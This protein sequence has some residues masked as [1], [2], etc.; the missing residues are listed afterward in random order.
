[1][2]SE[3]EQGGVAPGTTL[4][5]YRI[6]RLLGRGGMGAVFLA[7]DTTLHRQVAL[8]VMD[9]TADGEMSRTRVLREARNAAALNHPNICTI[10][11]V[12]E[13]RGAPF[14]AMEYVE[15]HSL[16]D[17]LDEAALSLDEAVRYGV[18]AADALAYA[19]DHGV[20]HRDFKVANA[21]ITTAGC[22]KVVDFGLARRGDAM[23]AS[24]TTMPSLVPAGAA[25]GTPY[26]MAPEQVRADPTDARTDIWALGVLLYEMVAGAKPFVGPTSPELF[27]SILRDAPRPLPATVPGDMRVL[28]ERCLEKQPERRYQ[29]AAEV[30]A[31]LEA[32]HTGT[33]ASW[34]QWRYRLSRRRWLVPA[35]SLVSIGAILV[36][37]DVGSV[38]E[39]LLGRPP[40]QGPIR[41]AV[42]PFKNLT[43][44]PEQEY[45]SDGLTD[46][47]ITQLGRLQPERLNVIARTSSM[48]Y[49]TRDDPIDQIGRELGV[50]Y[51]MEGSARREGSRVRISATLIRARDQTQLWTD[52]FERELSGILALQSD[53]ARGVAGS[54]AL[55]LLPAQERRLAD[56][57]PV[58]PEAY[59]AL[60]AGMQHFWKLTPPEMDTAEQY[61][62]LSLRRDPN[63][64]AAHAA[65]AAVWSGRLQMGLVPWSDG[66][67]KVFQAAQKAVELDAS[68]PQAHYAMFLAQWLQWNFVE[69]ER[70][71]QKALALNPNYADAHA[72]YSHLL[73]ILNR[74]QEARAEINRALDLDPFNATWHAFNG[75]DLVYERRWD[76]AITEVRGAL[77]MIPELPMAAETLIFAFHG[78]GSYPEAADALAAYAGIMGYV[79][80]QEIM[81]QPGARA[82]YRQLM[83]RA[84]DALAART[85]QPNMYVSYYDILIFYTYSGDRDRAFEWIRKAIDTHDPNVAYLRSPDLL[86]S[87]RDDP[88]LKE[89]DGAA[90]ASELTDPSER[91]C[92]SMGWLTPISPPL[93]NS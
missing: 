32:I 16:G 44:D 26:A 24:A 5:S 82:D 63:Y 59:E 25:A 9:G 46:E 33:G 61:V 35:A 56:A 23:I 2:D 78:K 53:V 52:S 66:A 90:Q 40:V 83:H 12:G 41:L 10:Y 79:E 20:V 70:E 50:D 21:I 55:R 72:V 74:P 65:V 87:L 6:E 54:L 43:G 18:Q 7:F 45:F 81:K 39:R 76:D 88:R 91:R 57:R 64:A 31:A 27:S 29:R 19:H 62:Q 14:I 58:D 22:L 89:N 4:G 38:R 42:L 51:V 77:K 11:E 60:S 80:V 8:K 73:N 49:K 1:M 17:R 84:A 15:G 69:S 30:R 34:V 68:S 13:A 93:V 48:R 47:M 75:V 86:D 92:R 3:G 85:Q 37:V 71:L 36:G 67:P 28:I